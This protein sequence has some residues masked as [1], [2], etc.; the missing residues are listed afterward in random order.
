MSRAKKVIL[1]SLATP[2][3]AFAVCFAFLPTILS[4]NFGKNLIT[5]RNLSI[6]ELSLSWAEGQSLK[7]LRY[8]ETGL[9][10]SIPSIE[11]ECSFWNLLFRS[12]SIGK[13]T[14]TNP[15]I[16]VD[17]EKTYAEKKGAGW[18]NFSGELIVKN[19]RAIARNV[20]IEG[21]KID[22]KKG[23]T[24][25]F[26]AEGQTADG[27]F[28]LRGNEAFEGQG[29]INRLPLKGV[30]ELVAAFYPEGRGLLLKV[31]GN[32]LDANFT[33]KKQGAGLDLTLALNSPL[34]QTRLE[35]NYTEDMLKLIKPM[36]LTWTPG[37]QLYLA[38]ASLN[39]E[40][41]QMLTSRGNFSFQQVKGDFSIGDR[42]GNLLLKF[43]NQKPITF[44]DIAFDLNLKKGHL[45]LEG[46]TTPSGKVA[47]EVGK[48]TVKVTLKDFS[49]QVADPFLKTRGQ[50]PNMIGPTLDLAYAKKGKNIDLK[51]DSDGLFFTGAF[52]QNKALRLRR[53]LKGSWKVSET[54]YDA[55]RRWRDPNVTP[56]PFK[57]IGTGELKIEL[58]SLLL[59][60]DRSKAT[61]DAQLQ[62]NKLKLNHAE[63]RRFDFKVT[64]EEEIEFQ[65][66]GNVAI[67]GARKNGEVSG[68]GQFSG[69]LGNGNVTT[70]IEAE[71]SHL[72]SIFIDILQPSEYPP[73]AFLGDLI[74]ATF[75]AEI[76]Q[77]RGTVNMEL[78]A[79][80][81]R[82]SFAG[83][84]SNGVLTLAK[85]LQALFTITPQLNAVLD[86]SAKLV[87]V[88]MEKPI[89]LYIDPKGFSVPLKDLHIRSMSL[90]YGQLDMGQIICQNSGSA[91]EISGI[92][93]MADSSTVSI[94]FAP[95]EF[96]MSR[97]NVTIDRTEIL[98]DRRYEVCL[99]GHVFFPR[100]YVDMTLGITA[101]AL[102]SFGISG[103]NNSYVLKV[104]V[105][106]P[107]GNVEVD[108]GA[109]TAKIAFLVARKH[110]AP[111]AGVFGQVLGTIG[112]LADNQS[113]VP[114]PKPPFPWQK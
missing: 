24:F 9:K 25:S 82:A 114:P 5:S 48:E 7:N 32:T 54:S 15:V 69:E 76:A 91:S 38:S 87:V 53:P 45:S 41:F 23:E 100:R 56:S 106:G 75:N 93:K 51:V 61:F 1:F 71:I 42:M 26:F 22:F 97:G 84:V 17:P 78:N 68:K 83:R 34:L 40:E 104:P 37:L 29:T 74:D 113:D 105:N 85:P 99:W 73:S 108:T 67:D 90:Q 65:F 63:L 21:I 43:P 39:P 64:K 81:C 6:G 92:F 62:L 44:Q 28:S 52:V 14:I 57:I 50:L 36:S 107:F 55:L 47:L 77:G 70:S 94:W 18:S 95:A 66:D 86:K 59:P 58:T 101:P 109:A 80:A 112:D 33:S 30:D 35:A 102:R 79:S 89:S 31:F 96:N 20:M 4:S 72:P 103:I 8:K 111:R 3:V 88:A 110:I 27:S 12:G 49:S 19:G 10:V 11:S 46:E 60:P 16:Q 2:A 13:T 98:Y